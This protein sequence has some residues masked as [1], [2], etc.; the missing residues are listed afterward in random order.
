MSEV[1]DDHEYAGD[2]VYPIDHSIYQIKPEV[3]LN[4]E[5]L[6]RFNNMFTES[7]KLFAKNLND[8][9]RCNIGS[10]T[11]RTKDVPPIYI[12]QYRLSQKEKEFI[13]NEVKE[14]LEADIIERSNSEWSFPIILIP[15]SDGSK[16]VC[17]DFR[18]LNKVTIPE[19]WPVPH[20][21]DILDRLWCSGWFTTLDLASGYW[22]VVIAPE[23]R[24]KTA[25]TNTRGRFQFK[26]LP[27]G[28]KNA[29]TAFI[30]IM[31]KLR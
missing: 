17:V 29:P 19:Y 20:I 26:R 9:S 13:D 28:L 24:P 6:I 5:E 2:N 1:V 21:Q 14:L 18:Q 12:P 22:Q 16:R 7:D 15:K 30:R 27:F 3:S 4:K 25:F 31:T 23:S 11:I 10:H 8:L